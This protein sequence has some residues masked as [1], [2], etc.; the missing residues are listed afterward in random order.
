MSDLSF[1]GLNENSFNQS[2]FMW[3]LWK[4]LKSWIG[5][6]HYNNVTQP[7]LAEVIIITTINCLFYAVQTLQY[8]VMG[9]MLVCHWCE[10]V[11]CLWWK[12]VLRLILLSHSAAG[13]FNFKVFFHQTKRISQW[14]MREVMW[15]LPDCAPLAKTHWSSWGITSAAHILE[16]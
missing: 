10:R 1:R 5:G 13:I 15:V 12:L 16:N 3:P 7:P 11:F 6:L 9:N 14:Q 4:G 8:D 2:Y